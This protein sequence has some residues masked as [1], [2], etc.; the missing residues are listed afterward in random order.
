MLYDFTAATFTPGGSFGRLGPSLAQARTGLTGPEAETWKNNTEYFNTT[1]GI[2]LWTVPKTGTYRIGAYGGQGGNPTGRI[3]GLGA[4]L[5]GD[6]QLVEG[7]I[8]RILVGQQGEIGGHSQNTGQSVTAG[9]GGSFV[10]RAP[11]NTTESILVVA[12]GGGGGANNTWT[13]A[14]GRPALITTSGNSGQGGIAGGTNGGGGGGGDGSGSGPGGAGFSGNGLVDPL[15]GNPVGDNSKSF[16]N[17]GL[18][19]RNSRSWGGPEI[20]GGFGGGGG[21]GGLAAGGGGGYSGGGGGSWSSQQ[22]GGGGGSFNNGEDQLNE[23]GVN[24]GHGY[25]TITSADPTEGLTVSSNIAASGETISITL[26]LPETPDNTSI[27]YV[28]T[29]VGSSDINGA[30]LTGNF[31]IID[32]ISTISIIVTVSS[33]KT[34]T[35]ESNGFIQTVDLIENIYGLSKLAEDDPITFTSKSLNVVDLSNVDYALGITILSPD[36]TANFV[37]EIESPSIVFT[38][39]SLSVIDLTVDIDNLLFISILSPDQ[40]A[41]FNLG[42]SSSVLLELRKFITID[43]ASRTSF[44]TAEVLDFDAPQFWIGA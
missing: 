23:A 30:S 33:K 28:I 39:V 27:P 3:G 2:Q 32:E 14:D 17:G 43:F 25:V 34:L 42:T 41:K 26:S 36:Q 10:V 37:S 8:I 31:I 13:V 35:I 40:T 16:I 9:G 5:L 18:G 19:G 15:S 21:G 22:A 11:Y 38:S 6:F 1:N 44:N 24:S 20:Y 7:E 29:G 4:T 12:G